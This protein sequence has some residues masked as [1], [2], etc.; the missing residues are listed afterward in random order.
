MKITYRRP[1]LLLVLIYLSVTQ[2]SG[3]AQVTSLVGANNDMWSKNNNSPVKQWQSMAS[4]AHGSKLVAVVSG[5]Q[6]YTSTNS[7]AMWMANTSVPNTNWTCVA[8]SVD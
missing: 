1:I 6:I 5:G 3:W 8:S 4:S 2:I 7:G